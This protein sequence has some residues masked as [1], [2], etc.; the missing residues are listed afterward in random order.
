MT[1]PTAP[2][3]SAMPANPTPRVDATGEFV[4]WTMYG[5]SDGH[6]AS[7]VMKRVGDPAW[8][9]PDVI[10]GSLTG[11]LPAW[12]CDWTE[13]GDLLANAV[14]DGVA[15]NHCRLVI[16]DRSGKRLRTLATDVPPKSGVTASWRKY[17]H[18]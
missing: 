13:Q 2:S 17:G 5:Q 12:F 18:Q 15:P 10:A 7:V 6:A 14:G 11:T 8:K 3:A 4:A 16:F 9:P 1:W